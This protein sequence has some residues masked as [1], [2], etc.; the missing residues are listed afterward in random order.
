MRNGEIGAQVLPA[1]DLVETDAGEGVEVRIA[2]RGVGHAC[3]RGTGVH[4]IRQAEEVAVEHDTLPDEEIERVGFVR[5]AVGG[6]GGQK[7]DGQQ[8]AI[9]FQAKI[10]RSDYSR[11]KSVDYRVRRL[12]TGGSNRIPKKQNPTEVGLSDRPWPIR[13]STGGVE[14]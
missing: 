8:I 7:R 14:R 12:A 4:A 2:A 1:V 9:E 6:Y 5:A 3:C 13:L 11:T 10:H